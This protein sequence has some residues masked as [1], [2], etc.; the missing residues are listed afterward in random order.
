MLVILIGVLVRPAAV[1]PNQTPKDNV[2]EIV[3]F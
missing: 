2:F 3:Y 1:T